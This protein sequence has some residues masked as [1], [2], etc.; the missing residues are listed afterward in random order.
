MSKHSPTPWIISPPPV[1]N[2]GASMAILA[3][4]PTGKRLWLATVFTVNPAGRNFS[5]DDEA[6]ANLALMAK[7]PQ[8]YEALKN[9]LAEAD[10]EGVPLDR[11]EASIEAMKLI[12]WIEGGGK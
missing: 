2:F 1:D 6:I 4:L 8:L 12:E 11:S 7:A 9:L 3:D 10:I 5:K